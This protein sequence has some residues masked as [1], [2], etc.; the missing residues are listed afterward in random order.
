MKLNFVRFQTKT[1]KHIEKPLKD[2][3]QLSVRA[4]CQISRKL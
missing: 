2:K 1:L 3:K 4:I